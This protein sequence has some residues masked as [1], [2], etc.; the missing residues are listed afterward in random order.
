MGDRDRV[1][2]SGSILLC[3]ELRIRFL[4]SSISSHSP[5]FC[6]P[7]LTC[8][9]SRFDS[10]DHSARYYYGSCRSVLCQLLYTLLDK[11]NGRPM[12]KLLREQKPSSL[13]ID[14]ICVIDLRTYEFGDGILDYF[15][16]FHLRSGGPCMK[17]S[18]KIFS[19]FKK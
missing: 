4:I 19:M 16:A 12:S 13:L 9:C 5:I 17:A 7:D 8:I 18:L 1:V 2:E 15:E 10:A 14:I 3:L 6:H 11:K